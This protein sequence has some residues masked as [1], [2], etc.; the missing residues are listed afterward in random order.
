MYTL[1][2][3][4]VELT[5][6]FKLNGVKLFKRFGFNK[7]EMDIFLK[8]FNDSSNIISRCDIMLDKKIK[9]LKC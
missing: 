8:T 2:K 9:H 6:D 3:L 5:D 7:E 4:K 1:K